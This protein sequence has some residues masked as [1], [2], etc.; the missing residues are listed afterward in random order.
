MSQED[1]ALFK[2]ELE[3]RLARAT[4]LHRMYTT[5]MPFVVAHAPDLVDRCRTGI[6]EMETLIADIQGVLVSITVLMTTGKGTLS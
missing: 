6:K 1:L 3:S 5:K 4:I 2:S